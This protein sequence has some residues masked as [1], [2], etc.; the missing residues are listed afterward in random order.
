MGSF[1]GAEVCDLCSLF[2]LAQ[3]QKENLNANFGMYKDDG[4]AVSKARPRQIEKIKQKICE[5]YSKWGL[6]ITIEA[7]K[8]VVQFLDAEFNLSEGSYK[9]FLKP[10][11]TPVYVHA[12]SNHPPGILKNVPLSINKRLCAL[13]S[14]EDKFKEVIAPYQQALVKSGYTHQLSYSP[15]PPMNGPP[16]RKR[17]RK[18]TWWNPPFSA[19]VETNIGKLFFKAME[20]NFGEDHPLRKIINKNTIKMSYRTCPNFKKIISSHNA[21]LTKA[22]CPD[23]PCNCQK[24][25]E[26]CPLDGQCRKDNIIYQATVTTEVGKVEKYVGMTSP[27]FKKR[28]RNHT[29][30][31]N[32]RKYWDESELSIYIWS[33]KDKNIKYDI[34][35]RIL[36]RASQFN[37]VTRKCNLCTLEK[38]YILFQPEEATLNSKHEVYKSCRHKPPNLLIN[39]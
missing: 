29:K 2:L 39:S 8:N 34:K 1:D 37:P 12:E 17:H 18:I 27:I 9:P 5:V 38:Y 23:L 22:M 30:S 26:V 20:E 3:L 31:F 33:L 25:V 11:A 13:S 28:Y 19:D 15:P 7:N 6:K 21:K 10:G 32:N 16:K 14:S 36:D 24:H 4:L 35:W